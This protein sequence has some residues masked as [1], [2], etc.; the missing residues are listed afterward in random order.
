MEAKV[1]KAQIAVWKWKEKAYE[2]LK[3]LPILDQMRLIREQT[4]DSIAQINENKAKRKRQEP[5]TSNS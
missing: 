2:S 5:R 1:S 4:R 3:H